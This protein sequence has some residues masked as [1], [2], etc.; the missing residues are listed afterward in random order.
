MNNKF[1]FGIVVVIAL[2]AGS[3]FFSNYKQNN[4]LPVED[5]IEVVTEPEKNSEKPT[6]PTIASSVV[7]ANNHFATDLYNRYKT[8]D[9][10]IFF[11]PY[12]IE[13]ALSMTYEG[14]K[15]E[16]AKEIQ[17]VLHLPNNI[18]TVH[19]GFTNINTEI[20]AKGKPYTISVANALWTQKGFPFL[21]EYLN[22]VD[23][24]YSGKATNLDFAK[25]NEKSRT[26]I[27]DWV[28]SKTNN[29]IKNII[30]SL[31]TDTRLV[32]TNAVYF[33]ADWAS[34]FESSGTFPSDF[35]TNQNKIIQASMMNQKSMYNYGEN[36]DL[37]IL[38]MPY[39]GGDI[40]MLVLLPKNN[41]LDIEKILTTENINSWKK[42]M[43]EQKVELSLPKFK[44]EA[45]YQMGKDL[46]EMG[47][48]TAFNE[49]KADFSGMTTADS[50]Y[51]S[52]VIHKSF[53]EVAEYGTEAAAATTIIAST[54]SMPQPEQVK[55]F[56]ADHPFVFIIQQKG[57]GN[58]LFMGRLSNPK[59]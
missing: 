14:A 43:V 32:L 1:I 49:S 56:R 57:T 48:P 30:S 22:T 38:E 58:I 59:I 10:N 16:T 40:S 35:T 2:V 6:T 34:K 5:K 18:E 31:S 50:L 8:K 20:N 53:I 25:Q 11:S 19:T 7:D 36:K 51:I 21:P 15:G 52:Q 3:M 41:I 39:V 13:S 27:N 45:E 46:S 26:I 44:F 33:K 12:S 9:G 37:Q 24:Y 17:N 4:N 54:T 55:Y 23:K 28:A 42:G 47:M 29:R